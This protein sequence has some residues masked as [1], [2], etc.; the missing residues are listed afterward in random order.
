MP[1]HLLLAQFLRLATLSPTRAR[2]PWSECPKRAGGMSLGTRAAAQGSVLVGHP[3]RAV[4]Q[5]HNPFGLQDKADPVARLV[6]V[7]RLVDGRQD[8]VGEL[9][10]DQEQD[11]KSTRL[12][13]SHVKISYAVV[14]LKKKRGYSV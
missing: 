9:A 3:R 10:R 14:C 7:H 11:R 5:A 2:F 4:G 12:N 13:S 6:E 1:Q 8:A